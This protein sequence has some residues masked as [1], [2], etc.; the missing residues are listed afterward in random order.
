MWEKYNKGLCG[1]TDPDRV[2]G[3]LIAPTCGHFVQ[4]DNP[5]FVA[6]QLEDLIRKVENSH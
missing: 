4:K 3:P 6:E 5:S 1:L 2:K